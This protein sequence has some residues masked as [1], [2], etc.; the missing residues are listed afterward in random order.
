[1]NLKLHKSLC[2]FDLETTGTNISKDRIVEICILKVNPDASRETKTWLV[3]PEMH[4]PAFATAVHGISDE[5]VKDAPTLKEIAPKIM[6]MIS[7][8]DLGGFNSNRFDVPLL[9]E[10]MLRAGVDFDLSK[11]KLV[12]AQVIFHKMEP[13]NLS[14]AYQFYCNKTLEDAHSAEADTLA[15]FEVL[16]A[17]VGKYE[18]LPKDINGLSEF[19]YHQK[20]ADLAGFIA[21]DDKG[22]EIF[23]FG[24]YKGQPVEEVLA[25]DAGYF[26]WVQN[27]D[28]P[29][30]TK[31]V[32]TSIQL[33]RKF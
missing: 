31:K 15:T 30:Y 27:A 26:G 33:R 13:R 17:Q 23:T 7:G 18:E 24:K 11:M 32:L 2:I 3:N 14:A 10:E 4:I 25:K 21:F 22:Q 19:S 6:E 16:D 29:L 12:D 5:D 1:M 28:F 8:A 20:F 9:A